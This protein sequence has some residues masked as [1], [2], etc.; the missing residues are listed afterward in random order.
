MIR[1]WR[2]SAAVAVVLAAAAAAQETAPAKIDLAKAQQ[3]A[4]Q[5]CAACH[6]PDG[7]SATPANPNL[8]GQHAD[9]ITLQLA[10]FKAGVRA[11][12]IMQGMAANLSDD[13]MRALGVYFSQQKPKG[14]T[15]KDPALVQVAQKIYRGGDQ[16]TGL[17]ACA[18]CHSPTGA[19]I[20]KN[21]PRVAGQYADYTYAQLKAFKSGD[22]GADKAGKDANGR[23]MGA[24]AEK[25]SDDQMKA[26]ADYMAGLRN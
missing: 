2:F 18:A 14:L 21:Y 9:Y 26:V 12:A 20:P 19:G 23:I 11:N 6:G 1:N 22:R 24:I 17:P 7:N 16:V 3:T 10:H 15:A 13:D 8:A 5:I 25:M 4:T